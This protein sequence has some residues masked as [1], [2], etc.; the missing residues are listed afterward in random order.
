MT[1]DCFVCP[2]TSLRGAV[3][4]QALHVRAKQKRGKGGVHFLWKKEVQKVPLYIR[5]VASRRWGASERLA[6]KQRHMCTY[7]HGSICRGKWTR[8]ELPWGGELL[9]SL[10]SRPAKAVW[11]LLLKLYLSNWSSRLSAASLCVLGPRRRT[12]VYHGIAYRFQGLNPRNQTQAGRTQRICCFV[13]IYLFQYIPQSCVCVKDHKCNLNFLCGGRCKN[14]I[15]NALI[16][17]GRINGS[18]A[19]N[20]PDATCAVRFKSKSQELKC[21]KMK[22]IFVSCNR[23]LAVRVCELYLFSGEALRFS[24]SCPV[25]LQ[26]SWRVNLWP[27]G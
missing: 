15:I 14:I 8:L 22:C 20:Q 5:F 24:R 6:V 9:C 3:V 7:R 16:S 23:R 13:Q 1:P 10:C 11:L 12:H 4:N 19:D 27:L 18:A 25:T 17:P 26:L 21:T 2:L